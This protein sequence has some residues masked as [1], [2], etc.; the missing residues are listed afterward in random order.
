MTQTSAQE[1]S[2]QID[3]KKV[4]C[5]GVCLPHVYIYI[6]THIHPHAHTR[7]LVKVSVTWIHSNFFLVHKIIFPSLENK[8]KTARKKKRKVSIHLLLDDA[9][10]FF[11]FFVIFSALS[12]F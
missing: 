8:V 1:V 9:K 6:F 12:L 11:F 2:I 10:H 3:F 4:H 5:V 7:R